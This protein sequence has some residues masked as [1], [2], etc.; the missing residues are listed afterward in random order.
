MGAAIA[1]G[2]HLLNGI[3]A[4]FVIAANIINKINNL[5]YISSS[6]N[7]FRISQ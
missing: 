5:L 1:A 6:V 4:L 3:W 7:M 2:N